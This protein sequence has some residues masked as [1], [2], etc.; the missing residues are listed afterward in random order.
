MAGGLG[1]GRQKRAR[2][3][4]SGLVVSASVL[5]AWLVIESS[6]ATETYLITKQDLASGSK[7]SESDL[8]TG[9]LALFGF[10]QNYLRASELPTGAY[11]SRAISAGE[12]IPRSAVTTQ[13]L[14]DWSNLVVTPS[15]ELSSSIGAGTKVLV[16]ASPALDYQSFGEPAIAAIDVEVVEIRVPQGN[17]AQAQSSVELRVPFDA[18]QSLLRSISNGDAIALTATGK[19]LAD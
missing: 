12:A 15:V 16:W 11:L 17:F 5:G 3:L 18:L 13:L 7:L 10:G 14:D 19:T 9:D 6:K 4:V 1:G 2:L 8:A